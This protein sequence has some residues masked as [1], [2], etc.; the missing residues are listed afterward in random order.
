MFNKVY[1]R[2]A[3]YCGLSVVGCLATVAAPN[4]VHA[5][6]AKALQFDG[7]DDYVTMG[8]S[9][10]LSEFTISVWFKKET[11]GVTGSSGAGGVNVIPLVAKGRGENDA[12]TLDCNYIFGINS[13][14]VLAADFEEGADGYSPGLNHPVVGVTPVLEGV[15][16]HAALSYDGAMWKVYLNGQLDAELYIGQPLRAD[17][18]QHFGLGTAMNSNG[19]VEGFFAGSLNEVSVWD[20]ALSQSEIESLMTVSPAGTETGLAG[21]WPL[22]DESGVTVTDA[23]GNHDGVFN[24]EAASM[25][26]DS[27]FVRADFVAP[28]ADLRAWASAIGEISLSWTDQATAESSYTVERYD[29]TTAVWTELATLVADSTTYV[30]SSVDLDVDYQ[31]RVLVTGGASSLVVQA[32]AGTAAGYYVSKL[33]HGVNGYYD[34][35]DIGLRQ[36][37]SPGPDA[38]WNII[39]LYTD[40]NSAT[41]E[42]QILMQ[43]PNLEGAI[44]DGKVPAGSIV[45]SATL[46]IWVGAGNE[47]SSNTI[48]MYPMLSDWDINSTW[49]SMV[50]GVTAD[51]V[52]AASSPDFAQNGLNVAS[53]WSEWD[54]TARVQSIIDGTHTNNGWALLNSGSNGFG[55][56]SLESSDMTLRP[57]LVIHYTLGA[58]P[59]TPSD[60]SVSGTVDNAALVAWTDSVS[61]ESNYIVER[62][63]SL[64]GPWS[65]LADNLP[66][67]ST[68]FTDSTVMENTK[69]FYRVSASNAFGT[70]EPDA[71]QAFRFGAETSALEFDGI[72]D[73]ITMGNTLGM[74]ELTITLW[75]KKTGEGSTGSTG[76]GGISGVPLVAKGRGESDGSTVDCNYFFGIDSGTGMLGADFEEGA[77]GTSPGLNH[78]IVGVSPIQDDV[79]YYAALTYD[80]GTWKLY[81]NGALE[82]ELYVGQPLRADSIQHFSIGSSLNSSGV[83]AGY[84]AGFI[85]EVSV[86]NR[87]L[88]M[89]EIREL[90]TVDPTLPNA[91]LSGFW[92]LDETAGAAA[93]DE[94]QQVNGTVT[95]VFTDADWQA[96]DLDVTDVSFPPTDL[97]ALVTATKEIELN[98]ADGSSDESGF[99]VERREGKNGEWI[100]IDT[101]AA[102]VESYIDTDVETD[103]EYYYRVSTVGGI[104][105]TAAASSNIGTRYNEK[106]ARFQYGMNGYTATNDIGMRSSTSPGADVTWNSANIYT[107]YNSETDED[108]ALIDFQDIIGASAG[109]I[110]STATVKSATLRL[111]VGDGNNPSNDTISLHRMLADWSA[112][113][114]WNSMVDGISADDIEALATADFVHESYK[115]TETWSE[116][117]VTSSM[118]A[119]VAGTASN[120]GWV[121]LNSD[122]DGFG[123][124]TSKAADVNIHPE[125]VVAYSDGPT[126]AQPTLV[127]AEPVSISE[128][129]LTWTDVATDETAYMIEHATDY[130]GEWEVLVSDLAPD[131][132]SYTHA[133]LETES[134]HYYRVVALSESGGGISEPAFARTDDG[135]YGLR[136]LSF[137]QGFNAYAGAQEIE[138]DSDTPEANA[139]NAILWVDNN[140]GGRERQ[141]LLNFAEIFGEAPGQ[142]PAGSIIDRAYVRIY[143]GTDTSVESAGPMHFQQMLVG[144]DE[145]SSWSSEAW[146]GN[147][148]DDDDVESNSQPDS[149]SIFSSQESYYDVEVT[150]TLV[151][152]LNGDPVYGWVIQTYSDDGYGFYSSLSA[153]AKQ[154]PELIVEIDTDPSNLYPEI[155]LNAPLDDAIDQAEPALINLDVTDGNIDDLLDVTLFGRLVADS[156]EAFSVVLLPDTQ[157]YSA[158]INGAVKEI[159]SNQTQWIIDNREALN[160][161]FVLHLGDIVQNGDTYSNGSSAEQEWINASDALYLLEDPLTTGLTEGIPYGV[162]VGNHDQEPIWDPDGTTTYYNKY[163]GV[164]HWEDK[165]YYGDHYGSNNDN[166][167]QLYSVG[168]YD[169]LS[170]SLEYRGSANADVLDWAEGLVQ[171]Y[172]DRR[173]IVTTHHLVNT[174]NPASW[175]TY[176]EAIYERLKGYPNLDLMLGGHIHG[177][178]QRE[179][180]FEGNVTHSLLQDYQG[181]SE[182][183]QGY[184]RILTF[185]PAHNKIY[186]S[187]YSPWV[188]AYETDQNSQ[189]ELEY[190]M[191]TVISDFEELT[192]FTGVASGSELEFA[193][194]ELLAGGHYEWY[195]QATDGRKPVESDLQSFTAAGSTYSSWRDQ[196]FDAEDANVG[197]EEDHD[198]DGYS[199]YYEFVFNENP[200]NGSGLHMPTVTLGA[201]V[202]EMRYQRIQ[203]AGLDWSYM[204]SQ[205]LISWNEPTPEVVE[206]TESVT[207]NEDGTESVSLEID[208]K[209]KALFWRIVVK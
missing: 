170:I 198:G 202:N 171:A 126:P 95:G 84:F 158:E 111:W 100:V 112:T 186:V 69:Y 15:W 151:A 35:L 192:T 28:P 79:W 139:Q 29:E 104:V 178:G 14:G 1:N 145:T 195:A 11:G 2:V 168:S 155:T 8:D 67:N 97:V 105:Y 87:A 181:Y 98:W 96:T 36:V 113:S 116:W 75:F 205:D 85:D 167:Y 65:T 55:I 114:T 109:Q 76:V 70:G 6:D 88:D 188:D 142:I 89:S 99:T 101:T 106:V 135:P 174:G 149:V 16:Q 64:D 102:N 63:Y 17:S 194:D 132:Q 92:K 124:W 152:W 147:G 46:R 134:T 127:V 52:E 191:G 26:V 182:G 177:E 196:L 5:D 169:F 62:A 141:V 22:D 157:F 199:N 136:Q 189:F 203:D 119:Y 61:D 179:D 163:F 81:L 184:L 160:I 200:K 175:S 39:T 58:V 150:P 123:F 47:K 138:I 43:F 137:Q 30:D 173:V 74:S 66:A 21:Y 90:M 133:G 162:A 83:P 128:I 44:T 18:I 57:E 49:N 10:G 122:N 73:Y 130:Y 148:I 154:R 107:D 201:G 159:F 9:L 166:Y 13:A 103:I 31:Y 59:G 156:D 48:S 146:G 144:W 180:H 143:V 86:W 7:V 190:D 4:L 118:E 38:T 68:E 208:I 176:G 197:R 54:L 207:D 24:G 187:T 121:L 80:G 164:D 60:T 153:D 93:Y 204:V 77:G 131:T 185:E 20:H 51:G 129:E 206:I 78:P 183:G 91:D 40:N 209:V 115:D 3:R 161:A 27:N 117:D 25:W 56:T 72:D 37:T 53:V 23:T 45:Q 140:S 120:R 71:V 41:N 34:A 108:Q 82:N 110:P 33:R 125:L 50:D 165:S 94:S 12:T 42:D 193:W 172:P 32:N 19:A